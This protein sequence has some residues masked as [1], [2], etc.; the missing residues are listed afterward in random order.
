MGSGYHNGEKGLFPYHAGGGQ[1]PPPHVGYAYPY[2]P[3][4]Y[5]SHVGYPPNVYPPSI[6]YQPVAYHGSSA[7]YYSGHGSHKHGGVGTFLAG[8]AAAVTASYG[9]HHMPHYGYGYHGHHHHHHHGKFKHYKFKRAKFGK[10]WKHGG[11]YG[12]HKMWK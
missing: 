8:G 4:G 9:T 6:G 7:P 12:R 1:Y 10:R 2:P 3:P 11:I 5:S